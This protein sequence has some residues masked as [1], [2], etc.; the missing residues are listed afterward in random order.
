MLDLSSTAWDQRYQTGDA[1][2][3]LGFPTPPFVNLLSSSEAPK[4]GR[5]AVLGCGGGSD[6]LLFAEAG[7]EVMGFD[8]AQTAIDRANARATDR[9]I[10]NVQFLQRDIF[11]LE[12]E[13][14][15]EFDYVLEH[16][17]FC[18]IDPE[19]R[20][21]YVQLVHSI[22]RPQGQLIAIFY[23]HGRSGGPPFGV[24]PQEVLDYFEPQFDRILFKP[25]TDS[26]D[27]RKGDEHLAIFQV[28]QHPGKSH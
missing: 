4:T 18:A 17:C 2:W 11:D 1:P 27:R 20:S 16:T 25:A 12:T 23:T 26:I 13:F 21:R 19:L 6:A 15:N 28:R 22:L 8:F 10:K 5:I 24:K 7:F 3:D 14:A 9:G